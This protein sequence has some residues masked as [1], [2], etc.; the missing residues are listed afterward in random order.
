[1]RAPSH[2]PCTAP[3]TLSHCTS[4][5]TPQQRQHPPAPHAGCRERGVGYTLSLPLT[6]QAGGGSWLGGATQGRT[7]LGSIASVFGAQVPAGLREVRER[8]ARR[9]WTLT[10]YVGTLD[11]GG[12]TTAMQFLYVNQRP[13]R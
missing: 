8:D 5:T 7:A 6:T 9:R 1:M 12:P 13:V 3:P 10:G 2:T 4:P 11:A